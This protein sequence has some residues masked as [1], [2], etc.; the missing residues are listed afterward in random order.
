MSLLWINPLTALQ[1]IRVRYSSL[2]TASSQQ[3]AL[4]PVL[5]TTDHISYLSQFLHRY[6]TAWWQAQLCEQLAQ[7]CYAAVPRPRVP[8]DTLNRQSNTQPVA[9][10]SWTRWKIF[11]FYLENRNDGTLRMQVT[12]GRSTAPPVLLMSG[13][14]TGYKTTP[15]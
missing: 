2:F 6:R 7:G 10:T 1:H 3:W 13:S 5:G 14:L 15:H 12:I 8:S 4:H 9:I 11:L